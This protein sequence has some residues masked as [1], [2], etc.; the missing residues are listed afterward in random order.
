VQSNG[1]GF[2][3]LQ[4]CKGGSL[5]SPLVRANPGAKPLPAKK[6][7]R[8]PGFFAMAQMMQRITRKGSLIA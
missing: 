2:A 3:A 1:G 8:N 7:P 4:W 5:S 6:T